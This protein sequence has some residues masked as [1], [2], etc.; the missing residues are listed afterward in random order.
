M[1][2]LARICVTPIKGTA[3]QHPASAE[4]TALGIQ[5]NRRFHLVDAQGRL[6]SG[7]A[8]G[9]LV[10]VR[11]TYDAAAEALVV[12]FPG[13]KTVAADATSLGASHTTDFWGR[14]VAGRFVGGPLDAA[15]SAYAGC[16][17]RLVRDDVEGD[18]P[19]EHRLT[20]MAQ[21]SVRDLGTRSGQPD[22]DPRRFRMNLE[23]AACEPFEEDTWA[24]TVVRV[25]QAVVRVLGQVPRCV[26]TT[27][28]PDTGRK[29]FDTLKKIA[30]FRPLIREPRG[31]PFGVYAEVERPARIAVG[32]PVGPIPG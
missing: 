30:E 20:L 14:P 22:L 17:V 25:G 19:D 6:F 3:L 4:L 5:G 2:T 24:G 1:A 10:Q 9:P 16:P 8:H 23:L 18:G 12:S 15:F 26:V 21:A 11:A 28:D 31:I 32:D 29:D 7:G 13:G 27:Q